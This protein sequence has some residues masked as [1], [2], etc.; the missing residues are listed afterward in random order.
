MRSRLSPQVASLNPGPAQIACE[1]TR[2]VL[3]LPGLRALPELRELAERF[4]MLP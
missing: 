2:D 4:G 3:Q 1:V